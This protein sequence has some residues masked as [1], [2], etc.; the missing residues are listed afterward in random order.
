MT[1][2]KIFFLFLLL[3]VGW[4]GYRCSPTKIEH[5]GYE[6]MLPDDFDEAVA[7]AGLKKISPRMAVSYDDRGWLLR[8]AISDYP[9]LQK[10]LLGMN[11]YYDDSV[12]IKAVMQRM[13][14][15]SK[16]KFQIEK[17]VLP[18]KTYKWW[19]LPLNNKVLVLVYRHTNYPLQN[20]YPLPGEGNCM[21]K[22]QGKQ[23]VVAFTSFDTLEVVEIMRYTSFDGIIWNRYD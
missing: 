3:L 1:K 17:M 19:Y 11:F 8:K 15:K 22:G 2:K 20:L 12:D 23:W 6:F 18:L 13:E 16:K 4:I 7:Q 9:Q 21:G 5:E 14:E 10:N